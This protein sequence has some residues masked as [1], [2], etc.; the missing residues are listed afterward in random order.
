MKTKIGK[1]RESST[2]CQNRV[3]ASFMTT[4]IAAF[5]ATDRLVIR[6]ETVVVVVNVVVVIVDESVV[7]LRRPLL[8]LN[9]PVICL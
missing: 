8:P 2:N 1:I 6:N 7:K 5:V 9:D 4:L 3:Y